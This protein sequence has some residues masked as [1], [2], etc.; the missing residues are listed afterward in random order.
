LIFA[1][2]GFGLSLTTLSRPVFILLPLFLV[3]AYALMM[4]VTDSGRPDIDGAWRWGLLLS[5]SLVTLLPWFAYNY[6]YFDRVTLSPAGGIGR[7]VWEASWQGVW[8]GRLQASMTDLADRAQT[9]QDL[10]ARIGDVARENGRDPAQ[11]LAYVTQWQDIRRIWTTPTAP[12]AMVKAR[13]AGDQEYLR[14]GI[15]NIRADPFA[16]VRRRVTRGLFVL[17]V[18]EVPLRYSQINQVPRWVILVIWLCQIVL[19]VLATIGFWQLWRTGDRILTAILA[20]P[21]FYVTVVHLPLLTEARQ[22]LPVKPLLLILAAIGLQTI[23]VRF[24]VLRSA[25]YVQGGVFQHPASGASSAH[26]GVE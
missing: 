8:P 4:T 7:A 17:W 22:S 24:C 2:A 3:G 5:A 13:I 11:M 23:F 6:E 9:S 16:Y 15:A 25:F 26:S 19:V 18:G 20:L 14:Q 1:A 12:E 10:A 21:L